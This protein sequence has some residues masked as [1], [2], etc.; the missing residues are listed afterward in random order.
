MPRGIHKN[1]GIPPFGKRMPKNKL[2]STKPKKDALQKREAKFDS[3][4]TRKVK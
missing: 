2:T 4:L 1:L 3:S